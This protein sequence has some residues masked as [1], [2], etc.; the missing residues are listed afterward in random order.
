VYWFP[1]P[2]LSCSPL[3]AKRAGLLSDRTTHPR[4]LHFIDHCSSNEYKGVPLHRTFGIVC[5]D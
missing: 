2:E 3:C 5:Q 4:A 1:T